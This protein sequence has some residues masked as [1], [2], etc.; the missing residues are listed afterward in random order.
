[1]SNAKNGCRTQKQGIF[2]TNVRR[3]LCPAF[4][5][6]GRHALT[7]DIFKKSQAFWLKH[8]GGPAYDLVEDEISGHW[9]VARKF[10][11]GMREKYALISD[12]WFR[13]FPG[14]RN[15]SW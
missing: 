13:D 10:P 2:K 1:M 8:Y 5:K 15:I 6:N 12:K 11:S 4:V 9:S 3:A 7:L 14:K